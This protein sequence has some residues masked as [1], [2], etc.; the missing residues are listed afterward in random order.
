MKKLPLSLYLC[1]V[2]LAGGCYQYQPPEPALL[3]T[4]FTPENRAATD[5]ILLEE[6]IL[7][8]D[9]AKKIAE[10]NN[11]NYLAAYHF[12]NAAR[13]RY[14]QALGA[15]S[16][17]IY[18]GVA[19]GQTVS[20]ANDM[21]NPPM[22]IAGRETTFQSHATLTA[23]WLLFD[24]FARYLNVLSSSSEYKRAAAERMRVLCML[25]RAVA[26]AYYDI[27]YA[28]EIRRIQNANIVF[29]Q[30]LLGIVAPEVASGKRPEDERL[31][32][33][34]FAGL[35]ETA[36]LDA[37]NSGNI[38][39][40]ALSQ[41]MGYSEGALPG[42]L[43]F[44]PFPD[45]LERMYYGVDSCISIA[46]QNSPEMHIM[47]QMLEIAYY[48]KMKSY[49]SYFPTVY[50]DFQYDNNQF[51]SH[52]SDYRVRHSTYSQNSIYYGIHA[53]LLLFNGLARYNAMREMQTLFAVAEFQMAET[54]LKIINDIRSAYSNYETAW[55][56]YRIYRALLPEA[57][58]Q[59]NL[60]EKRY[61]NYHASV[62]RIDKVQEYYVAIQTSYASAVTDFE[63]AIAQLEAIM[64]IN[65]YTR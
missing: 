32:F 26:Y 42:S 45:K 30:K 49:S 5:R 48:N 40:Y 62:D 51:N 6:K 7:K 25:K 12:V 9:T 44:E 61:L 1:A 20:G 63:K 27:Q 43:E 18:A 31:N 35:G 2:V 17:E 59:R 50:G 56:K 21:H 38:S 36:L 24:G 57:E 22:N 64:M 60:V 65:V 37:V 13:M 23:S 41:L 3:S 54:Y 39:S 16:P 14:Y 10:M 52:Y 4:K 28:G 29:Q 34:I 8:L 53:E 15:Y 11:Q 55:E 47:E 58:L 46:L 19:T 33:I